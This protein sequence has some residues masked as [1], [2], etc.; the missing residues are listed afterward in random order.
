MLVFVFKIVLLKLTIKILKINDLNKFKALFFNQ[1]NLFFIYS[2][3]LIRIYN[4]LQ[5]KARL[6]GIKIEQEFFKFLVEASI[7]RPKIINLFERLEQYKSGIH[8]TGKKTINLLNEV[9]SHINKITNKIECDNL[10]CDD[11][12]IK[13]HEALEHNIFNFFVESEGSKVEIFQYL[14]SVIKN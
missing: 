6:Q 14:Q 9:D 10:A 12:F 3:P 4:M 8:Q 1:L 13:I 2:Q 11:F 7:F 5:Y